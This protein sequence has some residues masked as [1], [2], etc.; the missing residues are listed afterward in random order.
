MFIV[1]V[2]VVLMFGLDRFVSK[3]KVGLAMRAVA[4]S[5]KLANLVGINVNRIVSATFIVG[6][7]LAACAGIMMGSYD[8]VAKYDMGFTP[9]IKGFT[10]A[11]LGGAGN[12]RGAIIG[13]VIIGLIETFAAGYVS[14]AYKD[15]FAFVILIAIL[16]LKP[17]GILGEKAARVD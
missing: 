6:G 9:G 3:S 11:I 13:G 2:A 15:F 5:H 4:E 16:V 17:S 10:A 1:L 7:L 14:V 12:I 8:G